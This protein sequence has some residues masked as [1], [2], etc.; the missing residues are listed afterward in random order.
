MNERRTAQCMPGGQ[1]NGI[2]LCGQLKQYRSRD[3]G[4]K[5]ACTIQLKPPFTVAMMM[6]LALTKGVAKVE[7]VPVVELPWVPKGLP[8]AAKATVPR[9]TDTAYSA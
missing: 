7:V 4:S 6:P 3:E 1:P 9:S 8:P 2:R 5:R